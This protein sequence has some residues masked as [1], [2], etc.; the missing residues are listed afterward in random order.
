MIVNVKKFKMYVLLHKSCRVESSRVEQMLADH[1]LSSFLCICLLRVCSLARLPVSLL[2]PVVDSSVERLQRQTE[3]LACNLLSR[4]PL[5]L[6]LSSDFS[7]FLFFSFSPYPSP[8]PPLVFEIF[9]HSVFSISF[10]LCHQLLGKEVCRIK[11]DC[12]RSDHTAIITSF[13]F[14]LLSPLYFDR[15][16][17]C[18]H[19][20]WYATGDRASE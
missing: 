7:P 20:L 4:S 15:A 12:G 10:S 16:F 8:M 1:C 11:S 5:L 2:V 9:G 3:R 13:K 14:T 17:S 6:F 19:F 18:F